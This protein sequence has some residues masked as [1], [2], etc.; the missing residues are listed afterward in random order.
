MGLNLTDNEDRMVDLLERIAAA[1]EG[2]NLGGGDQVT[3]NQEIDQDDEQTSTKIFATGPQR[4]AIPAD[5]DWI[6]FEIGFPARIVNVRTTNDIQIAFTKNARQAGGHMTLRGDEGD[7][8]VGDGEQGI[9]LSSLWVKQ[10][11]SASAE[12]GVEIIAYK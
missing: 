4:I 11:D 5:E 2:N 12:P 8:T 6:N 7:F 1:V 9:R 10:A 3:I